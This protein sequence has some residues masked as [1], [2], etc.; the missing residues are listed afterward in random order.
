ML[1]FVF[2]VWKIY[3]SMKMIFLLL[4]EKEKHGCVKINYLNFIEIVQHKRR[5]NIYNLLSKFSFSFLIYLISYQ[6]FQR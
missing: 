3:F 2:Y 6:K 1:Y 5:R 4:N